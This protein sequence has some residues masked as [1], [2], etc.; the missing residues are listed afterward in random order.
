[1][2]LKRDSDLA[3]AGSVKARG[4]I[5]EVLKHAEAR[6]CAAGL[7]RETDDYSILANRNTSGF[8]SNTKLRWAPRA[9]L[10]LSIGIMSA[11]AWLPR[12]GT[13]VRRRTGMEKR[14]VAQQRRARDGICGRLFR[15][16]APGARPF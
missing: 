16:R 1:M 4:G 13:H 2:L 5:Y 14:S 7:L 15:S 10:G 9:T 11:G 8:S 3:V 12:Y 6:A